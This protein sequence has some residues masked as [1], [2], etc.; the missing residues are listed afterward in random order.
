MDIVKLGTYRHYKG[1]L[2]EVLGVANHSETLEQLVVY[3][4]LEAHQ[5]FPAG[6]LWV[7]PL[8]MFLENVVV[9][10]TTVPRFAFVE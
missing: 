7:R 10:G 3:K 4:K 6:T 5:G 1:T 2:V 8:K 9:G